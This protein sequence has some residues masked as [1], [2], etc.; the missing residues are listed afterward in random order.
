MALRVGNK[1]H[2]TGMCVVTKESRASRR[3]CPAKLINSLASSRRGAPADSA[4]NK[5]ARARRRGDS[6]E[7]EESR[8]RKIRRTTRARDA[9]RYT[10]PHKISRYRPTDNSSVTTNFTP[11]NQQPCGQQVRV[12]RPRPGRRA[13]PAPAGAAHRKESLVTVL[14]RASGPRL[15]AQFRAR[16]Y[17]ER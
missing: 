16:G 13:P 2:A 3:D 11:C 17:T 1:K 14:I 9:T 8:R 12:M 6:G 4:L 7:G 5:H 10:R 15:V